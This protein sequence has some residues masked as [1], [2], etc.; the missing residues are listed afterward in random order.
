MMATDVRWMFLL[1]VCVVKMCLPEKTRKLKPWIA[2]HQVLGTF[3]HVFV[4]LLL[5]ILIWKI[6][7]LCRF[8]EPGAPRD[9]A[10]GSILYWA[11]RRRSLCR[12]S[13]VEWSR[14]RFKDP[15]YDKEQVQNTVDVMFDFFW[16]EWLND[17]QTE[18]NVLPTELCLFDSEIDSVSEFSVYPSVCSTVSALG[19][20]SFYRLLKAARN[21]LKR[22]GP[23]P[24]WVKFCWTG[25]GE[26]GMSGCP[27]VK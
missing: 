5:I 16:G 2:N 11:Q 6:I 22:Y 25:G 8:E 13:R 15:T 24:G 10:R 27:P 1:R 19:L 23:A 7:Q 3:H 26:L 20:R 21:I 12:P 18:K 17:L 4:C 9:V 14:W